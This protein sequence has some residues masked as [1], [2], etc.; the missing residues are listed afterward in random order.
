MLLRLVQIDA[1]ADQVLQGNPA[2]VMPLPSWLPDELLQRIAA[3]NN[4]SETAYY[5]EELP[6]GVEAPTGSDAAYHLRWFTPTIE[7]DLCGHATLATAGQLFDDAHPHGT[8]I[9]FWTR[10]GWLHVRRGD[11]DG[12]LVMDFPAEPLTSLA[13]DDPISTAA[14]AAFGVTAETILRGTDLF[15][16]LRDANAVRDAAP[17]F[18]ALSKLP[19]RGVAVT[20]PGDDGVDFVSRWFGAQAGIGE[21]PVTGSS[22]SQ[23][24]PYWAQRLSRTRLTGRQLSAR[25]GTVGCEVDG[26]R[27]LLSGTHR[28]YLDGTATIPDSALSARR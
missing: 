12:A 11:H 3:E 8:Q 13:A 16:V 25:G 5:V 19:L 27:I 21:D 17:D 20:A 7:V 2:A 24:A 9:S 14:N 18:T 22:H 6:A 10:S 26:D 28:R 1:F 4:L 15:L 23:L